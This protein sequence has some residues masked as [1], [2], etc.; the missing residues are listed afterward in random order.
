MKPSKAELIPAPVTGLVRGEYAADRLALRDDALPGVCPSAQWPNRAASVDLKAHSIG[1]RPGRIR[2]P[3]GW[4][5]DTGP[6]QPA[7]SCTRAARCDGY[8][9]ALLDALQLAATASAADR[10]VDGSRRRP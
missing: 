1:A 2:V 6:T 5:A 7:R 3:A 4:S 10:R 9:L 8:G